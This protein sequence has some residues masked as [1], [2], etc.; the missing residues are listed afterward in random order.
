MFMENR[1]MEKCDQIGFSLVLTPSNIWV[2]R[3]NGNEIRNGRGLANKPFK[4]VFIST[5]KN[6]HSLINSKVFPDL[7]IKSEDMQKEKKKA[8]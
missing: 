8:I 5:L 1:R 3:G 7:F 4:D 6:L 2:K